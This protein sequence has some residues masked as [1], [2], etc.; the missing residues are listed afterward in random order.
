MP[1]SLGEQFRHSPLMFTYKK[2]TSLPDYLMWKLRGSPGPKVPHRVK[3]RAVRRAGRDFGLQTLVETG[4][5]YGQMINAVKRDFQQIYSVELDA[6]LFAAAKRFFAGDSHVHLLQGDSG[7]VLPALI[8]ELKGPALFWLDAH[9]DTSPL[10]RE[11]G[12]ILASATAG[13]AIL[14]DDAHR[15]DGDFWGAT[16]GQIRELVASRAPDY[17][18]VVRD[19]IIHVSGRRVRGG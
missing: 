16:L 5:Q 4:T 2:T 3:E 6:K 18:V 1:Q 12:A 17:E 15:F 9:S 8:E 11:L 14:I 10:V 19:N 7:T 13:H